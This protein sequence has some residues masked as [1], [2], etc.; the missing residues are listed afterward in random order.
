MNDE[1]YPNFL[2]V[3]RFLVRVRILEIVFLMLAKE[4]LE[5]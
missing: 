4:I 5:L 1:R 3:V 2:L